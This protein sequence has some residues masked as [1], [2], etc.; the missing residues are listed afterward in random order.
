MNNNKNASKKL[1]Y[2]IVE[3]KK[4][5]SFSLFFKDK[6]NQNRYLE[7]CYKDL[8]ETF[9][10]N[11]MEYLHNEINSVFDFVEDEKKEL[12]IIDIFKELEIKYNNLIKKELKKE[13][14]ESKG[15]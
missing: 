6:D 7:I 13:K 9:G 2:K 3:D 5:K 11:K 14:Q 8:K 4:W 1:I 10:N 15:Q 12:L